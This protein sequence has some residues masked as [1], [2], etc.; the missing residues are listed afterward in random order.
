[1]LVN[2]I[3]KGVLLLL[4]VTFIALQSLVYEIEGDA[5]SALMM[6]L[7]IW[8]YCKSTEKPSQLFFWFLL[9]V[10]ATQIIGF[11]SWFTP[12]VRIGEIDY[13]YYLGNILHIISYIFLIIKILKQLPLKAVF[14]EF[15]TTII[16]LIVLD[17]FCV[18]ILS[19]TTEN[20]LSYYENTLEYVYNSVLMIL[21]SFALINYMYRND[22]KSMLFLIGSILI[23]FSEIIQLA[24][25]YILYDNS[26]G[27]VYSLFL[28][29]AFL[30]FYI[31]SQLEF[32]EPIP[33]YN[34]EQAKV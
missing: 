14:S 11:I 15:T 32:S 34:D 9:I 6:I 2:K 24:Y 17:V 16:I 31:Q 4:G 30:F 5:V 29:A 28:V 22:N 23:V 26:L 10:T 25:F 33:A 7:L 8:L 18:S 27:F 20:V 19:G 1:M 3:L 12:E 13:F 21:L